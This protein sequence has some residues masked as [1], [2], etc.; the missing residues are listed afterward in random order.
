M[1]LKVVKRFY[2]FIFKA[3]RN[4]NKNGA[5]RNNKFDCV[6]TIL[7]MYTEM[8]ILKIEETFISVYF[9]NLSCSV[10]VGSLTPTT[11]YTIIRTMN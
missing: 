8:R 1:Y 9:T 11:F 10:G 2:V 5:P 7:Y 3:T 4:W 6:I